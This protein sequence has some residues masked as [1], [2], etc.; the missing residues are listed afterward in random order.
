MLIEIFPTIPKVHPNSSFL[1]WMVDLQAWPCSQLIFPSKTWYFWSIWIFKIFKIQYL[2]HLKPKSY[3]I[4]SIKSYSSRYSH[5]HKKCVPIFL[6]FLINILFYFILLKKNHH[7]SKHHEI[8]L[9]YPSSLITFQIY[10]KH[11]LKHPNLVDLII[12][13]LNKLP[14]FINSSLTNYILC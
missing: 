3:E 13:K 1:N 2:P 12:T 7:K 4:W 6:K 11:N 5:Q 14:C 9:M 8:K 10:Q